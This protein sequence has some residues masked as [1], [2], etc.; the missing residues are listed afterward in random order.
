MKNATTQ[1]NP[2]DRN[3]SPKSACTPWAPIASP[4]KKPQ[5][6]RMIQKSR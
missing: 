6:G 3:P 1:L 2:V 5:I 4:K